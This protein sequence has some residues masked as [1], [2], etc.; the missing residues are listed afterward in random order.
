M[1]A[2]L[3]HPT[4]RVGHGTRCSTQQE[5]RDKQAHTVANLWN[6]AYDRK[7]DSLLDGT[8]PSRKQLYHECASRHIGLVAM[9]PFAAGWLFKPELNTGFSPL[10]LIHYALSQPGV[11]CVIPG[12]ASPE[13]LAQ[14]LS[15][16]TATDRQ[17]DYSEANA[18]VG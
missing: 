11:T 3:C 2:T 4:T 18:L 15:Y 13:Q 1:P 12:V 9:K 14:D 6:T 7:P 10:N 17:K 5:D 16:F 8:I